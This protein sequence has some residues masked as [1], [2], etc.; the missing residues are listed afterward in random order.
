MTRDLVQE[1]V[2]Y[3]VA[4]AIW[5]VAMCIMASLLTSCTTAKYVECIARDNTRNP[6]N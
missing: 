2:R 3:C 4:G 5:C 1:S 6:C